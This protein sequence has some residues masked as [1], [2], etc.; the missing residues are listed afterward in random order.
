MIIENH[1]VNLD[2]P[3]SE[4]WM[5]LKNYTTQ[6]DELIGYY[7][8]DFEGEELIF[9]N[10]EF[11]KSVVVPE[12]YQQEIKSIASYCSYSENEILIANL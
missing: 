4:R 8:G 3:P 12:S 5:F 7:L 1:I 11:Y 2:L 9:Q 10:L 6:I